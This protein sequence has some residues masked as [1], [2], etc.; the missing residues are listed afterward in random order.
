M[1]NAARKVRANGIELTEKAA[2]LLLLA[3]RKPGMK[4]NDNT[5]GV[6]RSLIAISFVELDR[7]TINVLD[8]GR[9][10][11]EEFRRTHGDYELQRPMSY[12]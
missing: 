12:Q 11:A 10:W 6:A 9:A 8:A 2:W 5:R 3:I 7:G 1:P 4:C